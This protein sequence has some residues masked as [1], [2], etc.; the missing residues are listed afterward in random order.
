MEKALVRGVFLEDGEGKKREE[1][2][3]KFVY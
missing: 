1:I 2:K 3:V